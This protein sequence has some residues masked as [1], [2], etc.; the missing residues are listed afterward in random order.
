MLFGQTKYNCMWQRQANPDYSILLDPNTVDEMKIDTEE[1]LQKVIDSFP[2]ELK[3]KLQKLKE[4]CKRD[5]HAKMGKKCSGS[6]VGWMIP[7]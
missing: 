3:N 7:Y 4:D 2:E 1:Q 6:N 5:I